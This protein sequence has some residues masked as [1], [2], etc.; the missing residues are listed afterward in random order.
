MKKYNYTEAEA[1]K[2]AN[3]KKSGDKKAAAKVIRDIRKKCTEEGRFE[4]VS[5]PEAKPKKEKKSKKVEVPADAEPETPQ[6]DEGVEVHGAEE[7]TS[8]VIS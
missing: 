5:E 2:I 1:K 4:E 3:A 8:V 7:E 6:E